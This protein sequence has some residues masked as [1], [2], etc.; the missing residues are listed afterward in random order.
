MRFRQLMESSDSGD[1]ISVVA[2]VK[3]LKW[4][5]QREILALWR[6]WRNPGAVP[7]DRDNHC[8]D[9]MLSQKMCLVFQKL[10][11]LAHINIIYIYVGTMILLLW[12][13]T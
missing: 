13:L 5:D 9:T 6:R 4:C 10:L 1:S 2:G 7:A 8:S 12:P 3:R 11:T